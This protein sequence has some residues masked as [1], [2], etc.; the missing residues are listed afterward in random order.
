[1]PSSRK[2]RPR[3]VLDSNVWISAFLFGGKPAAIIKLAQEGRVRILVSTDL[4]LEIARVLRYGKL[5]KILE[6][7]KRSTETVVAQILA[8]TELVGTKSLRSWITQDPA[9][10]II[11]NCAVENS[12][13]YIITGDQHILQL[14]R[15]DGVKIFTPNEFLQHLQTNK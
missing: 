9:D 3:L 1:M 15:V 14:K 5:R 11:L 2:R 6:Q 13:D 8:V 4:I 12:A 7:S 10:D